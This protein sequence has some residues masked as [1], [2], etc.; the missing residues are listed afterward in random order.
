MNP[1]KSLTIPLFCTVLV[2]FSCNKDDPSATV[3]SEILGKWESTYFEV[4]SC[5]DGEQNVSAR[6]CDFSET[7][8]VD[9]GVLEFRSDG[10]VR[11]EFQPREDTSIYKIKEDR[12]TIIDP[13]TS[14]SINFLFRITSDTLTLFVEDFNGPSCLLTS[15]YVRID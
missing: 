14:D 1:V 3:G 7:D 2:T 15:N 11:E 5:S 12:L 13:N 6:A 4:S 8:D 9:C 10:F